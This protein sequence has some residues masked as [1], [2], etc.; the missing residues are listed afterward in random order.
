MMKAVFL[1]KI[2]LKTL[3]KIRGPFLG[4]ATVPRPKAFKNGLVKRLRYV[5]EAD[6]A[7]SP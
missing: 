3:S 6:G 5:S 2:P 1:P 7:D 4:V